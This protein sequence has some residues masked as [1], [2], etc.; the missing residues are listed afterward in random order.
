MATKVEAATA[1]VAGRGFMADQAFFA[2]YAITLALFIMFSFAQFSLRGFVDIRTMPLVVHAHAAVMVTWLALFV[3]QNQLVHR[4]EIAIHRK[5]GWISAAVVAA[6]AVL[7]C[8]VGYEALRLQMVPPFFTPGYFLSLTWIEAPAFAV[9]VAWA[10]S[11]RRRTE[12]HRRIMFGA[13]F[14]LLEPALGRLLPM[15]LLGGYGEWVA[16]IVQLGF[17]AILA[18][19][20]KKVLGVVHPATVASATAL[21]AVHSLVS[22]VSMLPPV[23]AFANRVAGA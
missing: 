7:G 4:G 6:V 8:A 17:V 14:I 5:L 3:V 9:V 15:P 23:I 16:L 18:R 2:R 22:L 1:S 11:L 21:V 12:W 10:A 13:T 19:H 20:D